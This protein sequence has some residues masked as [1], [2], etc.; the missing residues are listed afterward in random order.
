MPWHFILP[1]GCDFI[2]ERER[3]KH[4]AMCN[5]Y[6]LKGITLNTVESR[7]SEVKND[8]KEGNSF[9]PLKLHI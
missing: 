6:R 8:G 7:K 3:K 5:L 4:E 1:E 2:K 9:L